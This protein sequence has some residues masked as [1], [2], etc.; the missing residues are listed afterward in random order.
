LF[1]EVLAAPGYT[2]EALAWLGEHKPNCRVMLA[3][4]G[5][6]RALVL[7]SVAAGLLAQTPDLRGVDESHVAGS[8]AART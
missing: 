6:H 1:V 5:E 7:R 3:R 4:G 2:A 8:H